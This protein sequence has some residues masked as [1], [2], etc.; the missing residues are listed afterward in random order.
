M[1]MYLFDGRLISFTDMRH[2]NYIETPLY[3]AGIPT[4]HQSSSQVDPMGFWSLTD[5]C[6]GKVMDK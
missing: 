5:I 1:I 3:N 4:A 2:L 6:S